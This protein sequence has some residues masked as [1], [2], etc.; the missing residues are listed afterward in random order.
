M[1]FDASHFLRDSVFFQKLEVFVE[2]FVFYWPREERLVLGDLR[3]LVGSHRGLSLA[4]VSFYDKVCRL[5][6]EERRGA[7][8][9]NTVKRRRE[10]IIGAKAFIESAEEGDTVVGP[11]S[12]VKLE[13]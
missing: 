7:S 9:P 4:E 10:R 8:G 2:D 11:L 13:Q 5:L 3:S 12:L 6:R 1:Q